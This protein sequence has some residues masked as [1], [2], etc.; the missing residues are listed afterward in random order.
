MKDPEGGFYSAED[1]DV[2]GEEGKFYLWTE[3][4]LEKILSKDEAQLT[5]KLFNLEK[6][7]NFRD[8]A[9]HVKTGKNILYLK[10]PF[11]EIAEELKTPPK[12]LKKSWET[13][14]EKLFTTRKKRVKPGK[15]D[16]ILTD[17]NSLMIVALAKAAR[18]LDDKT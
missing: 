8:E 9:T 13:I 17:W 6:E 12:E 7:G 15:D 3:D 2:E 1:A 14:R 18:A 5:I 16:K 10:K 11:R 4:E